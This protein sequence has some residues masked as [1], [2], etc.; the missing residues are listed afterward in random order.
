MLVDRQAYIDGDRRTC[1]QAFAARTHFADRLQQS[2]HHQLL[3]A[4]TTIGGIPFHFAALM[5]HKD[6]MPF[7]KTS[8]NNLRENGNDK[9]QARQQ[10]KH[11]SYTHTHTQKLYGRNAQLNSTITQSIAPCAVD[12]VVARRLRGRLHQVNDTLDSAPRH[13]QMPSPSHA[14][15]H[16]HTHTLTLQFSSHTLPRKPS[17]RASNR[18]TCTREC[19]E[20]RACVYH[21]RTHTHISAFS[22]FLAHKS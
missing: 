1:A 8:I 22:A 9:F 11:W 21:T 15:L 2:H 14:P 13:P 6:G 12:V 5:E 7:I 19:R 10:N 3:N 16:T 17:D 4:A 20:T 18:I